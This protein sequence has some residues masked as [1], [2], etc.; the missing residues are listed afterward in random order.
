MRRNGR[1]LLED[2]KRDFEYAY[3]QLIEKSVLLTTITDEDGKCEVFETG[4]S[5]ITIVDFPEKE[6]W[7]KTKE[8][9]GER[10]YSEMKDELLGIQSQVPPNCVECGKSVLSVQDAKTIEGNIYH[11]WCLGVSPEEAE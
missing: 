1:S 8:E 3:R 4:D 7:T 11:K 9:L 6:F 2:V 5:L 10:E